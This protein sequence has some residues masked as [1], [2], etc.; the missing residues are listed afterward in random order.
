M[1]QEDRDGVVRVPVS[2]CNGPNISSCLALGM[3]GC[4]CA[5]GDIH[6]LACEKVEGVGGPE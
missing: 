1:Q 6:I 5:F 2:L 3:L 4:V